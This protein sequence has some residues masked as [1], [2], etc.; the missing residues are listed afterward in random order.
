MLPTVDDTAYDESTWDGN[1]DAPTKNAVRDKFESFLNTYNLSHISFNFLPNL[2]LKN[3]KESLDIEN[4]LKLFK[5]RIMR[6]SESIK[7]KQQKR[8]NTLLGI[9]GVFT[10]IGAVKPIFKFAES[11]RLYFEFNPIL[12]YFIIGI[13]LIII[14]IPVLIYLFPQK[15]KFIKIKWKNKKNSY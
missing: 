7:E 12:Y 1:T 5:K 11:S 4:E 8:S 10:S 14:S 6:I 15:Y 3:H 13:I 9:V 2:I